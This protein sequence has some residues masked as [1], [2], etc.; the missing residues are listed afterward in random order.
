LKWMISLALKSN[1]FF[2]V[3]FLHLHDV[4]MQ[5]AIDLEKIYVNTS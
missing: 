4:V 5:T 3:A 1:M 2:F